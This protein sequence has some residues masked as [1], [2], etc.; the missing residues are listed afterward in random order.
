VVLLGER[1]ERCTAPP[2]SGH[3]VGQLST[4]RDVGGIDLGA[5]EDVTRLDLTRLNPIDA[6]DVE[7]I[8]GLDDGADLAGRKT[9]NPPL[10]CRDHLT[11]A[12]PTEIA[13]NVLARVHRLTLRDRLEV[14]TT[15]DLGEE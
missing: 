13:A 14:P 9:E 6:D 4:A 3:A 7:A 10:E 1:I 15:F 8:A 2:R 5:N 12:R 11:A